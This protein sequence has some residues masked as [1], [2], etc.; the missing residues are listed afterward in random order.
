MSLRDRM[1]RAQGMAE[2]STPS[3]LT[4]TEGGTPESFDPFTVAVREYILSTLAP[5][6]PTS[7]STGKFL[8]G[9]LRRALKSA[10]KDDLEQV[11]IHCVRFTD[12]LREQGFITE[13]LAAQAQAFLEE[14]PT[15]H[16]LFAGSDDGDDSA[17]DRAA[18]P[19]SGT[20]DR[21][22]PQWEVHTGQTSH[23]DFSPDDVG[24]ETEGMG[25]AT[26]V[27]DRHQTTVEGDAD[28]F[29]EEHAEVV[30]ED[31]AG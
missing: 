3:Q 16:D 10:S 28:T 22:D 8:Y 17:A 14:T 29:G 11:V 5:F 31:G 15:T 1:R 12:G 21:T 6:L 7:D 20:P 4:T 25:A 23:I 9:L 13:E 27:G 30:P 24:G 19:G 2:G 18:L 26:G